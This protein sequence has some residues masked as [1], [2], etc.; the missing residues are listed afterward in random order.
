MNIP[1]FDRKKKYW[2]AF[3]Q[4][5]VIDRP[6][7][8]VTSLKDGAVPHYHMQNDNISAMACISGNYDPLLRSFLKSVDTTYY[9]GESIPYMNL[10]LGPDQYAA[11]L[12]ADIHAEEGFQTTWVHSIVDDWKDFEVKIDSRAGSYLDKISRFM[13]YAADFA[14]GRFL[15]GMLDLHS[16]MD[17]LSALRGPQD[18]CF[19]LMDCPDD[20]HRVLGDVR[21]TYPSVFATAFKAG[22][23]A[24]NGSIGWAPTYCADGRFAVIQCDFSCMISPD[25][26]REFV[27]PAIAE[28]AAYLDHC[29][30]H[31]DGK[32]ALGHLDDILAI[33]DIDVI[34]WVPGDG[35]PRSIE[36]MDLLHRIQAAGKGL[37][38]YDWTCDEIIENFRKLSP[39]GLVF[40]VGAGSQSEADN[41]L[42]KVAQKM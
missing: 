26:A 13:A 42:E 14:K 15:I 10:T 34:Q 6:L 25:Q 30:Y 19:D 11:F 33:P 38:I 21:S 2:D 28:E 31:Y 32:G 16:N 23:M 29:V 1:D 8:C 39:E 4:R 36:W 5:E 40:S 37:W 9:G 35:N 3:W 12:G 22:G 41:L 17:A 24:K 18:L 7:I 20:V 27:I